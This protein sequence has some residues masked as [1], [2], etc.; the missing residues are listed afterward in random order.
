MEE[1]GRIRRLLIGLSYYPIGR[2]WGLWGGGPSSCNSTA[3]NRNTTD[4][5]IISV[6]W[7]L[8]EKEGKEKD[9]IQRVR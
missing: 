6:P 2:V 1:K 4:R 9:R 3:V 8:R 5:L 7:S